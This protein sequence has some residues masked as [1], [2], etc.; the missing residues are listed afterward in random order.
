MP[1][2]SFGE[3]VLSHAHGIAVDVD[4]TVYVADTANAR[5]AVFKPLP[6]PQLATSTKATSQT[7]LTLNA[8]V[9]PGAGGDVTECQFEY[10]EAP[11]EYN[12]ATLPCEP[13]TAFS[14]PQQV[15]ADLTGLAPLTTYHF[16]LLAAN[17]QA[18]VSSG[19]QTFSIPLPLGVSDES[20]S[21]ITSDSA[22]VNAEIIAGGGPATYHVEY[23]TSTTAQE[24][25]ARRR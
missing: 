14:G 22:A 17:A 5:L 12:L 6:V 7:T 8:Q 21:E 10:G 16:R 25:V 24:N 1:L 2:S 23:L 19:D 9:D 18:G 15:H 20:T 13:A 3:P 11:G 4:G